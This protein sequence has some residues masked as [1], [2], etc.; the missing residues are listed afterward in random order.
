MFSGDMKLPEI[1]AHKGYQVL[2][3]SPR[4]KV[5]G[6]KMDSPVK[7]RKCIH[8]PLRGPALISSSVATGKG[9]GEV[10]THSTGEN[11]NHSCP[12]EV[13]KGGGGGYVEYWDL[14]RPFPPLR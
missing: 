12:S 8:S 3:P 1:N 14:V 2:L 10:P 11:R 6:K 5:T 9:G 7:T 13:E 4:N